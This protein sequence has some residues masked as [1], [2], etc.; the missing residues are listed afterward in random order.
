MSTTEPN[1]PALTDATIAAQVPE[2]IIALILA[3]GTDSNFDADQDEIAILLPAPE[4]VAAVLAANGHL[5]ESEVQDLDQAQAWLTEQKQWQDR[6]MKVEA[7]LQRRFPFKREQA[8]NKQI[9][10]WMVQPWAV[11]LLYKWSSGLYE[12]VQ[13][14]EAY[15]I[16]KDREDATNAE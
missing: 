11:K 2:E 9:P 5:S 14:G 15:L 1:P 4:V 8:M 12:A 16:S 10:D 6:A 3:I 7:E 13:S